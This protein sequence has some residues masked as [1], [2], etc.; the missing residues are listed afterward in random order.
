MLVCFSLALILISLVYLLFYLAGKSE[1]WEPSIGSSFECGFRSYFF[2]R[3]SF[4]IHY[5]LIALIFLFLDLEICLILP[6]LN[7]YFEDQEM[8]TYVVIFV[9]VLLLG[10]L[11]EWI[12]SKI[13]WNF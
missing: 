6:F 5:F 8:L 7:E 4:S 9:R 11:Y 2:S 1:K 13:E 3:F 12:E 10:L